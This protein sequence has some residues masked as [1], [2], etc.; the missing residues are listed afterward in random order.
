MKKRKKNV[1]RL[2]R[3]ITKQLNSI[4]KGKNG[5]KSVLLFLTAMVISIS[6]AGV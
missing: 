2:I 4:M 5:L 1:K 6:L 3:G